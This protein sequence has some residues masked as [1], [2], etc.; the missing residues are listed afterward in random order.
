MKRLNIFFEVVVVLAWGAFVGMG[1]SHLTPSEVVF[2]IAGVISGLSFG[3]L[4]AWG[5]RF[6]SLSL[7]AQGR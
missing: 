7:K 3:I 4:I 2:E 6:L 1:A 5:I